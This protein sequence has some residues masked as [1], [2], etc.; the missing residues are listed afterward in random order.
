MS[1]SRGG[2]RR[3]WR[4]AKVVANAWRTMRGGRSAI[5]AQQR[6]RIRAM[7]AFARA[8]SPYYG[9]L[10]RDL[11]A[12][13]SDVTALPVTSKR[14]LMTR[15][16]EWATDRD[17]TEAAVREFIARPERIGDWFL[18][19]Y[20]VATTSGTTGL[21]GVFLIDDRSFAVSTA[22]AARML[23]AW[24]S[25]GDVARVLVRGRRL[26]MVNAIGGHFASAIAATRL[27]RRAPSRVRVFPVDA[28]LDEIVAGLNVYQ[29]ALLAPY[30]SLGALLASEQQ[31]GR[32]H[33]DP[34]L[35]VLSAEG[36][37]VGE[38]GRIA[39]AFGATVRDSYAATEC[40]FLSYRCEHDWLHVNAD[41]VVIEPVDAQ[42]RSVTPGMASHTVL[43][44]NL[45]NRVQPIVRYDLGDSVLQR[46]DPC[47]CGNP[48][49]AIQVQGRSA[50]VLALTVP[51]GQAVPLAPLLFDALVDRVP[52][53]ERLQIVQTAADALRV[54]MR[55]GPSADREAIWETLSTELVGLLARHQLP[56]VRLERAAEPPEQTSGGKFRTV[57]PLTT[58]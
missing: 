7:I 33:I 57:I 24:L 50:D 30:A 52:G 10:Y 48:L 38:R 53:L 37:P 1:T 25:A 40:P 56:T 19:R 11:P 21:Q 5:A 49:P 54:R 22:M 46:P 3:G 29:P 58:P 51:G 6:E 43:L 45:A 12:D 47:P 39:R 31:S 4:T 23:G 20:T 32:L 14:A 55:S 18:G 8:H 41:W 27:R 42:H 44:T 26:A 15:F 35:V 34:V 9:A 2:V 36:L 16:D 17:I 13:V 28:P